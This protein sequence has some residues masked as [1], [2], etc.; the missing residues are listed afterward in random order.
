MGAKLLTVKGH[1]IGGK[2]YCNIG[3]IRPKNADKFKNNIKGFFRITVDKKY[4]TDA[5]R[6][7]KYLGD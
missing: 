6:F 3:M 2:L 1:L 7:D 5:L 4:I